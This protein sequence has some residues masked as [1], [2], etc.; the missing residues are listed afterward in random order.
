MA[1]F[2]RV[3]YIEFVLERASVGKDV[4]SVK[5]SEYTCFQKSREYTTP[6]KSKALLCR[7]PFLLAAVYNVLTLLQ[8]I[9]LVRSASFTNLYIQDFCL[10]SPIKFLDQISQ[11]LLYVMPSAI[12]MKPLFCL[13]SWIIHDELRKLWTSRVQTQQ[14]WPL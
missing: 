14:T 13:L 2:E 8:V 4:T 12:P 9:E 6:P 11:C 1:I 10:T 7:K 5:L 3:D